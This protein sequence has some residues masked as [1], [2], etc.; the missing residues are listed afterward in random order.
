MRLPIALILSALIAMPAAAQDSSVLG[1]ELNPVPPSG[2]IS[3]TLKKAAYVAVFELLPG[4]GITQ[5]YPYT[6]DQARELVPAG[7]TWIPDYQV[8]FYRRATAQAAS[9][10]VSN[11]AWM[12]PTPFRTYV[13]IASDQPLTIGSPM[14]TAAAMRR[15]ERWQSLSMNGISPRTFDALIDAVRP[16]SPGAIVETD[17]LEAIYR[18]PSAGSFSAFAD[19]DAVDLICFNGYYNELISVPRASLF[20]VASY[21]RNA[22]MFGAVPM[23]PTG[24][25]PRVP[26]DSTTCADSSRARRPSPF[27]P[28]P[29]AGQ[30]GEA[31]PAST[32]IHAASHSSVITEPGEIARVFEDL[33]RGSARTETVPGIAIGGRATDEGNRVDTRRIT[34]TESG[35]AGTAPVERATYRGDNAAADRSRYD[36]GSN[37]HTPAAPAY[38]PPPAPHLAPAPAV[39]RPTAPTPAPHPVTPVAPARDVERRP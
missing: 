14:K 22:A 30:T 25:H 5:I 20:R 38:A 16:T 39:E 7:T 36:G 26:R 1:A 33:R 6:S 19:D 34:I 21:C 17:A 24:M 18:Q 2:D 4:R 37:G 27:L 23:P 8:A 31:G 35:R 11:A 9:W 3:F 29:A 32:G 28:G 15:V 10:N 13:L 12:Q